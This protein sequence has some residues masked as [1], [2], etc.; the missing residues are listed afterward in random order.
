MY[1]SNPFQNEEISFKNSPTVWVGGVSKF[2]R[3]K[4]G[5]TFWQERRR[6]TLQ[7]G[8]VRASCEETDIRTDD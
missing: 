6:Q 8:M 5:F 3:L 1:V 4:D 2:T 7:E